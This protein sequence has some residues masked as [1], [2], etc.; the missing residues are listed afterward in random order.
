MQWLQ[1]FHWDVETVDGHD[2][3]KLIPALRKTGSKPRVVIAETIKGKGVSFMEDI[4]DWHGKCPDEK[5]Y[6]IAMKELA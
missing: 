5:E 1:A 4:G 3:D 6:K 2:F